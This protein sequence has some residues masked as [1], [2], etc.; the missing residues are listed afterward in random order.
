MKKYL[1]LFAIFLLMAI[2]LSVFASCDDKGRIN[3]IIDEVA[4]DIRNV[5]SASPTES[6]TGEP[7]ENKPTEPPVITTCIR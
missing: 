2:S 5:P 7:S 6:V 3:Q 1:S 4:D